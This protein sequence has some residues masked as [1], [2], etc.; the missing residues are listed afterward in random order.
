MEYK[1]D[2]ERLSTNPSSGR[3]VASKLDP[4]KKKKVKSLLKDGVSTRTIQKNTGVARTTIKGVRN[5]M[6]DNNEFQLGNWKKQTA[7]TL[8]KFVSA[9]STRLLSEIDNIPVGQL[10][11]AIAIMTDKIMGLQDAPTTIVEHRLKISHEEINT[12]ITGA[13]ID[14]TNSSEQIEHKE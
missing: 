9:G 8:A 3:R 13:I 1:S 12:L 2:K 5:E 6:E 11:L 7:S 4:E 10:P 14:V